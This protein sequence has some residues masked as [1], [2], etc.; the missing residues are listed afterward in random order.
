LG[1]ARAQFSDHRNTGHL[2]REFTLFELLFSTFSLA[3]FSSVIAVCLRVAALRPSSAQNGLGIA[4][5]RPGINLYRHLLF[6]R[7]LLTPA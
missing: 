5:D 1:R 6:F 3:L 4:A 7:S 2:F